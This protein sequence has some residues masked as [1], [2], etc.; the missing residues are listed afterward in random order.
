MRKR[1]GSNRWLQRQHSDPFVRQARKS[2][3]RSRAIFKLMEI[4]RRDHLFQP[5]HKVIDLG[6]AP[7]GWS[8][9][10]A[11]MVGK[12]G[13]VIALDILEMQ[14]LDNVFFIQG[15]FSEQST[16][17]RCLEALGGDK[18]DLVISDMSP[19][20]T[21]I[22]VTDQARSLYLAELALEFAV[23]VLRQDGALLI[24][25]FQGEGVDEFRASLKEHFSK[26]VTRK[27]NASRD[28]SREFYLLA[29]AFR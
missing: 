6:A 7:G 3:Y 14:P 25:L 18:A 17:M 4:D 29:R 27:P 22:K 9:Y 28:D 1:S 10:V 8:Q 19:N 23:R 20:I 16:S 21:G 11:G 15:D 24:K 12:Q 2:E 5:G 13:K 26:I